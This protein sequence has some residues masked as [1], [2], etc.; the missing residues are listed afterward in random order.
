MRRTLY[1]ALMLAL[2]VGLFVPGMAFAK[3]DQP[4]VDIIVQLESGSTCI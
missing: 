4:T 1:F 2:I 3:G